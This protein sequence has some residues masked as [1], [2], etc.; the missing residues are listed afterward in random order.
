MNIRNLMLLMLFSTVIIYPAAD[1]F[2]TIGEG[3]KTGATRAYEGVREAGRTVQ[4][5]G[6]SVVNKGS[7]VVDAV[8]SVVDGIK[9]SVNQIKDTIR[10][11]SRLQS[12]MIDPMT[13]L[14]DQATQAVK[15]PIA[16][17]SKM[18]DSL[19]Q[20]YAQAANL[21]NK[22]E[23]KGLKQ[24]LSITQDTLTTVLDST[25]QLVNNVLDQVSWGKPVAGF[26]RV[27][28]SLS[29][30]VRVLVTLV[31]TITLKL[32]GDVAEQRGSAENVNKTL[33]E[34][35]NIVGDIKQISG[36]LVKL[37]EGNLP[38]EQPTAE[39]VRPSS[40]RIEPVDSSGSNQ[41]REIR[42]YFA[43]QPEN[44]QGY[45]SVAQ[46]VLTEIIPQNNQAAKKLLAQALCDY[47]RSKIKGAA[48]G[49][50]QQNRSAAL[51]ITKEFDRQPKNPT[52]YGKA[53][54]NIIGD[55]I[56]QNA[57]WRRPILLDAFCQ[58]IMQKI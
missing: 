36:D 37:T 56:R 43:K 29:E 53:A 47:L 45:G 39:P 4:R 52:G 6:E 48:H 1:F 51:E 58:Q 18:A 17:M 24:T 26:A 20:K 13:V 7:Q 50:P 38:S 15:T 25:D 3:I 42:S 16:Q 57:D 8:K 14:P 32:V 19:D 55:I 21:V 30:T 46:L 27:I 31:Q 40:A 35:L 22:R 23:L 2:R 49:T 10:V 12:E 28:I 41:E 11:A 5:T 44:Y 34:I 33:V 54:K 9:D